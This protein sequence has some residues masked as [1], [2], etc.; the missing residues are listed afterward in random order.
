MQRQQAIRTRMGSL[1]KSAAH[2]A[3]RVGIEAARQVV[4][5][6]DR[7][8]AEGEGRGQKVVDAITQK[9]DELIA[10]SPV[11]IPGPVRDAL[12]RMREA[13]GQLSQTIETVNAGASSL[14]RDQSAQEEAAR[15]RVRDDARVAFA[16]LDTDDSE[17]D[18]GSAKKSRRN[19][20]RR[21]GQR[22]TED[23]SSASSNKD[24]SATQI[25][26]SHS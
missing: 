14:A 5:R 24:D 15:R 19:R 3:G 21:H 26:D 9:A 23:T 10:K 6:V 25:P 16:K 18:A 20:S 12:G 13:L 22:Q 2:N 4:A 8:S 11:P 17:S 1:L 7:S